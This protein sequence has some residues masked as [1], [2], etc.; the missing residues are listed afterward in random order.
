MF[1]IFSKI[2]LAAS[3]I[4]VHKKSCWTALGAWFFSLDGFDHSAGGACT[5]RSRQK[6]THL[7]LR[8][9]RRFTA[10]RN[11]KMYE[12]MLYNQDFQRIHQSHIVNLAMITAYKRRKKG[13]L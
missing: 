2:A 7:F 6:Y 8:D 11:L 10:S 13:E 12:E 5:L 3:G 9:G 1:I 4:T